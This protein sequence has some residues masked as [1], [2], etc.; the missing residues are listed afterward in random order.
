M[1]GP[2]TGIHVQHQRA[3]QEDDWTSWKTVLK[4][5]PL[6]RH[7]PSL[8][9]TIRR[10]LEEAKANPHLKPSFLAYRLN[11]SVATFEQVLID[12]QDWQKVEARP[13]PEREGLC[14]IGLDL[15]F[16]RSHGRSA[17]CAWP[18]GRIEAYRRHAGNPGSSH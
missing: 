15:G 12:L 7:N 17:V 3:D 11:M 13:V 2:S 6:V 10:E 8:A 5:N 14:A 9:R 18:N 1:R 16:N 4:A